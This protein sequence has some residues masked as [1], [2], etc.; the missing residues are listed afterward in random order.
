MVREE[1]CGS[2]LPLLLAYDAPRER[3]FSDEQLALAAFCTLVGSS[4][5]RTDVL[6]GIADET[7][8]EAK[9]LMSLILTNNVSLS[10]DDDESSDVYD[11]PTCPSSNTSLTSDSAYPCRDDFYFACPS[12]S[13]ENPSTRLQSDDDVPDSGNM[14]PARL[15]NRTLKVDDRDAMRLSADAMARNIL[16]SFQT[17][18]DWR[19]QAWVNALSKRL[20]AQER[21]MIE[22]GATVEE[23]KDLLLLPEAS[24]VIALRR[25]ADEDRIAVK[26]VTTHFDVLPQRVQAAEVTELDACVTVKRCSL[27]SSVD[28]EESEHGLNMDSSSACAASYQSVESNKR[29]Y[30]YVIVHHLRLTC[31]VE[32]ETPAG[33]SEINIDVPGTIEGRFQC[34]EFDSASQLKAVTLNLDTNIL[35]SMVEKSCRTIVRASTEIALTPNEEPEESATEDKDFA[36]ASDICSLKQPFT[37]SSPPTYH[38]SDA[39]FV[40][41]RN[42]DSSGD[43]VES[44]SSSKVLPS[45]PD[46]FGEGSSNSRRV[47]PPPS[48]LDFVST[49]RDDVRPLVPR[50]EGKR[51]LPIEEGTPDPESSKRRLPLISPLAGQETFRDVPENGPSLPMLVEVACRA[52]HVV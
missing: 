44:A 46:D 49:D 34:S 18:M 21:S 24:L 9:L 47:S 12:L 29:S 4:S 25:I 50:S 15:L 36:A 13:L 16:L 2:T 20:V 43:S 33:F 30:S 37:L 17:A 52:M 22:S 31:D 32:L 42:A 39:A 51:G 28:G 14:H 7:R 26:S 19:I 27:G 23:L 8:K 40:T 38:P 35:A 11:P 45:I 3:S 1:V 10:D 5:S 6:P 48:Q 41:P